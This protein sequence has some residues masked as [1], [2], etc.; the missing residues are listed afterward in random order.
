MTEHEASELLGMIIRRGN[1]VQQ[2]DQSVQLTIGIKELSA[3]I[4][5]FVERPRAKA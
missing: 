4:D 2:D 1:C 5:V 3:V